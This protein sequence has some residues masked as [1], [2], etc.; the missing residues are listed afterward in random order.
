[1]RREDF[2]I[3]RQEVRGRPLVYLDSAATSQKPQVV[4]DTLRHYYEEDNANIHRGVH[5]LSERATEK[6]E[7]ARVKIQKFVN[8]REARE[9]LFVRGATEGINLAARSFGK[10]N[11][12][13]GD[14][15]LISTMEHHS[16]IVPWQMICEETGAR[17]RVIPISDDG[18]L[19]R[20]EYEKLLSDRTKIVAITHVSNTLGTINPVKE[21]IAAAHKKGA[22]VLIDGAQAA[23]HLK[24]DVQD[25]DCDFYAFSG[26]KMF[27]PTGIGVLYGK[28][29]R[30]EKMS[31]Y[32]GGGDMIRMVSFEKT[33]YNDLPYKFE[34]GTPDIAGAIGLGAAVDYL[35]QVGLQNTASYEKELLD[36]ATARLS[37]V[38]G[39]KIIGRAR[40]K[41]SVVSFVLDDVHPHDI[42]TVLDLEGIAIRT[43]HH[44]TMPLMERLGLAATARASFAFYNTKEEVDLLVK[45]LDRVKKVFHVRD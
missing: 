18:E 23:P 20:D 37:E 40:T 21:M 36:Y 32:Q 27:G 29:E 44:C 45:G 17:L 22:A 26:H 1:M 34:A 4:I 13:S 19:L 42:G 9:V 30:L 15:V 7:E 38:R 11:L 16:N 14:E 2:P 3:F 39:L 10:K 43:G 31:P 25:L 6:Y 5:V 24:I 8:A 41:A 12:K 35:N 28:A 33:T